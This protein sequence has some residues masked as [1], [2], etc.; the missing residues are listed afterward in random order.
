M[1]RVR[2]AV[3]DT[4]TSASGATRIAGVENWKLKNL[5]EPPIVTI[6]CGVPG[7]VMNP[8]RLQEFGLLAEP[9]RVKMPPAPRRVS[10]GN[11][12]RPWPSYQIT[13]SRTRPKRDGS[14][15]DRSLADFNYAMTCCTGGKNIEDTIIKLME[16][17][18]N[19][20]QRAARG[21]EGYARITVENAAAAV[22][23]NWGRNR[24]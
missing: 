14:G 8:E 17:S 15:P 13:L 2:A 12:D 16:V 10:P 11:N 22:A 23:R 9:E 4:D 24:A 6:V 3:G 5:P 21:D 7:R 19:A 1:R 20:Q 18:E